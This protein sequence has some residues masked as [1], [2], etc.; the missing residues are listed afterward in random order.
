VHRLRELTAHGGIAILAIVFA[1][2]FAA[3]NVAVSLAREAVS[4]LEQQRFDE[5]GGDPLS[6]TIGETTISYAATLLYTIVVALLALALVGVWRLTRRA[7][8]VCPE[9]LSSVPV[10]AT[11]CRYCTTELPPSAVDA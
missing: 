1:L 3:F 2:A 9:C 10:A 5:E 8:R 11:T 4:V 6:F 7:V